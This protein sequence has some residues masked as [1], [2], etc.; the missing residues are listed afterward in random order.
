MPTSKDFP[1]YD[2]PCDLNEKSLTCYESR[3]SLITETPQYVPAMALFACPSKMELLGWKRSFRL[4][5]GAVVSQ[6]RELYVGNHIQQYSSSRDTLTG[7]PNRQQLALVLEHQWRCA[8]NAPA[9]LSLLIIRIDSFE[10]Y[11]HTLGLHAAED[12]VRQVA[13]FLSNALSHPGSLIGRYDHDQFM[14]I[15]PRTTGEQALAVAKQLPAIIEGSKI[16]HPSSPLGTR[17][18]ISIGVATAAPQPQSKPKALVQEAEETLI[19]ARAQGGNQAI[20]RSQ[21]QL[22]AS[23]ASVLLCAG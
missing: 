6:I 3:L 18:T 12:C 17:V 9:V 11:C 13:C 21:S 19:Q 23:Q 10:E 7:T 14:V 20:T 16:P 4:H 8:I 1:R 2:A 5:R 22:S 15:L